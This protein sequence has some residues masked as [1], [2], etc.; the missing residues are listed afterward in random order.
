M[1]VTA[2]GT[3]HLYLT[4]AFGDTSSKNVPEL[5]GRPGHWGQAVEAMPIMPSWALGGKD[6]AWDPYVQEIGTGYVMYFSARVAHPSA[7]DVALNL[8]GT[9][10]LGVARST[11]ATGPFVPVGNRPIV[12][13]ASDGGD[14]DIQSVYY[15][16]GPGGPQHPRYLIWKS[17]NNN[18]LHP[19]ATAIWAAPLSGDG[20]RVTGT[21]RIIFQGRKAW[22]KPVLEAPQLVV[23][24]DGGVWL[25]FSAGTNYFNNRYGIGVAQCKGPL[26]PC[27]D[28]RSGPLV[29]T[30]AQGPG[31]GE[32]TA[33]VAPDGSLW[34]LYSP[35]HSRFIAV[36][37]PVEAVRIGWNSAGPYIA[38][39][40]RF[41][42]PR[43]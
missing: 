38:Q 3:Y 2:D 21:P 11:N 36:Y 28:V 8:N 1:L 18:L 19:T 42:S 31:P 17:D 25:F 33:F 40:G 34:L 35:W 29:T 16:N 43:S 26:G 13:Q 22:E 24:P 23:L 10:C 5:I 7:R 39:A 6:D 15:P 37:R 9:H 27:Y 14:I 4:S 30:N 20:L 41:P 12:C 32:E